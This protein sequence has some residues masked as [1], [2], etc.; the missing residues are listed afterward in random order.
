GT[1]TARI[2]AFTAMLR[3]DPSATGAEPLTPEALQNVVGQLLASL[4]SQRPTIVLLDDLH[5]APAQGL[6]LFAALAVSVSARRV[7]LIGTAR[8]GLPEEWTASLSRL[9]QTERI[10]LPRLGLKD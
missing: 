4:S 3:G 1:G 8:H 7:M 2:T 5:H 9:G 10:T 6:A